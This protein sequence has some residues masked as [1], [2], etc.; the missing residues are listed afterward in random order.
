M[1]LEGRIREIVSEQLGISEEE[2]QEDS[3]FGKDLGADSLDFCELI[4]AL[5]EEFD[6]E[7]SEEEAEKI[8]DFQK[9]VQYLESRTQ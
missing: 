4:M 6:I 7:I 8:D 9:M 1:A 2:I 3:H 5:E